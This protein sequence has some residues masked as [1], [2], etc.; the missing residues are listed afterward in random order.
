MKSMS[1]AN[2]PNI[3]PTITV[4]LED[5]LNLLL[6]SVALE[7]LGLSHI[8]NAEAE[9]LQ[10]A[11]GTLPGLSTPATIS[12]LLAINS[13]IKQTLMDTIKLELTLEQKLEAVLN[14]PL[15][16]PTGPQG[17]TGLTGITGAT[18]ITGPTGAIGLTGGTGNTGVNGLTGGTGNAGASGLTGNT[19]N[20]GAT[21]LTGNNGNTGITGLTGTTGSTGATGVIG[22][23][24]ATGATGLTG[25]IGVTGGIGATGPTGLTGAIGPTGVCPCV[26]GPTGATGLS[27]TGATGVTGATGA[28]G[29][30]GATGATG[31][32]GATG[33]TG[34]QITA[35]NIFATNNAF[36]TPVAP[37][38]GI[39]LTDNHTLNGTA[40]THVNGSPDIFLAPNQTYYITYR[41]KA[42][43][44]TPGNFIGNVGLQLNGTIIPST[45]SQMQ[46][47]PG[48]SQ[49]ITSLLSNTIINTPAG[50]P[51]LLNL[52]NLEGATDTFDFTTVTVVKLQ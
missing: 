33:L 19:G 25:N 10:Y 42:E 31:S 36:S 3:T 38:A 43:I 15:K 22:P 20:T 28:T 37:G 49:G 47:L 16:G 7:E 41:T 52:V 2:I 44:A 26:V 8:I 21:G 9:K 6:A 48:A 32:T 46:S 30:T 45:N 4:T 39:P 50:A 11:L 1:Q 18:G 23:S 27:I 17:I 12:D 24:G 51:S 35:N 34:V 5:S 14:T 29:G 40:I 13:S